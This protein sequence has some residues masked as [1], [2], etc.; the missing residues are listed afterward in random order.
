MTEGHVPVL[1]DELLEVLDPQPGDVAIDATFGA[2]GHARLV[3]ERI[4]PEG[5]LIGIDRDPEAVERFARFADEAPCR[6][7][8]EVGAF[9]QVL[10]QLADE[11]VRADIVY[12]DLGV[13]S[14]QIDTP[15][16][17]F[18]YSVDAPLDMRMDTT[19]PFSAAELVA[20]WD[21]RQLVSILREYGEERYARQIARA[22]VREREREPITTTARLVDVVTRAVPTPARFTGGHPAKRTFQ[23]LRIA[24]ND[25]LGQIDAGLP[26]A[27]ECLA[28][29]SRF[30]GISFHSLE[31]RRVKHFLADLA[32]GCICPPDL[33]ICRC[34]HE[35]QAELLI[36]GGRVASEE[37]A[38]RN[39]RSTSARLRAARRLTRPK[40]VAA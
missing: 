18:S 1:A 17:G 10:E 9:A 28:Q 2:G 3:A 26:A 5:L 12:L 19:E 24:V 23:A 29:N 14:M 39:P 25:E 6:T 31:D 15:Q 34:G 33:P 22:I 11:G 36:R 27:W 4:G 40:D 16:R 35:P 32:Q 7:R 30:A 37:E 13:S 20:T 38:A 8:L 21:E